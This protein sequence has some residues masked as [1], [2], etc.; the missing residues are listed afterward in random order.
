MINEVRRQ[1]EEQLWSARERGLHVQAPAVLKKASCQRQ[2]MGFTLAVYGEGIGCRIDPTLYERIWI[3]P[4]LEKEPW[5]EKA[6]LAGIDVGWTNLYGQA[7]PLGEADRELNDWN[8][9]YRDQTHAGPNL[10]VMNPWSVHRLEAMGARHIH[11]SPELS[12]DQLED[13]TRHTGGSF[14]VMGYGRI[15]L[16]AMR[17]CP[18]KTAGLCKA[19]DCQGCSRTYRLADE[20]NQSYRLVRKGGF[21]Y[22][23]SQEPLMHL[24]QV[25]ALAS[26]GIGRMRMQF[27]DGEEPIEAL[28]EWMRK[29]RDGSW[30]SKE[31][32]EAWIKQQGIKG[33]GRLIERGVL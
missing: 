26:M 6:R 32:M 31:A 20:N 5:V 25:D 10:F 19:A 30:P 15:P 4:E 13:L 12:L 33:Q 21:G 16:M 29:T 27:W 8:Q 1:M 2:V 9:P 23:L 22:L 11:L 14:E 7:M 17:H 28:E 24:G 18:M 3:L